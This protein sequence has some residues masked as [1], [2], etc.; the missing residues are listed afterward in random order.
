MTQLLY[1]D[2]CIKG[3]PNENFITNDGFVGS[4]LFYPPSD[5]Q[6][7]EEGWLES[8]INWE[9]E[10]SV[11]DFTLDARKEDNSRR[12][13]S[14]A[15]RLARYEIDRIILAL[16]SSDL[17]DYERNPIPD[18]PHH[19]NILFGEMENRTR[20]MIAGGLALHSS[21]IDLNN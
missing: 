2:N 18:N 11:V 6:P 12:Y 13:K 7:N 16:P 8:S 3:I 4:D 17:L 15:I 1:P 10:P 5:S 9:D 14:G 21:I 19:G 20:R